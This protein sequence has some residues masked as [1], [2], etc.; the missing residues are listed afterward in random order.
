M[1]KQGF[2][3][4]LIYVGLI[5][6]FCLLR[7]LAALIFFSFSI[8]PGKSQQVPD[9]L[10]IDITAINEDSSIAG[11]TM[12]YIDS[13]ASLSVSEVLNNLFI[14]LTDFKKRKAIPSFMV[15]Y[16]YYLKL[17]VSMLI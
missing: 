8:L 5:K 16:T 12:L 7:R 15:G 1:L 3:F 14:P 9:T 10:I 2:K 13:S 4:G 6:R 11:K 17:F